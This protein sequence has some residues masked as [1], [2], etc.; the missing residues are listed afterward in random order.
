MGGGH[1]F[2]CGVFAFH[3]ILILYFIFKEHNKMPASYPNLYFQ[4]DFLLFYFISNF[5]WI[6][7][8]PDGRHVFVS[9]CITCCIIY[10]II[11]IMGFSTYFQT[12]SIFSKQ[13]ISFL[14]SIIFSNEKSF[15]AKHIINF[16]G[17]R[18]FPTGEIIFSKQEMNL[19]GK[20]ICLN[21]LL[22][23]EAID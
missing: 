7:S 12:K 1:R 23:C 6:V 10:S 11:H 2:G 16:R 13:I 3:L 18:I 8:E 14:G 5:T 21:G 19:V 17:T 4:K 15:F 22:F 9:I 20:L